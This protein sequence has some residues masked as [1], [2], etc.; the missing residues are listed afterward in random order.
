MDRLEFLK[1]TSRFAGVALAAGSLGWLAGCGGSTLSRDNQP[2]SQNETARVPASSSPAQS[3]QPQNS[4]PASDVKVV[5]CR[6]Y[7]DG[8]CGRTGEKCTECI[9][10]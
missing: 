5:D 6:F 3:T 1:R 2:A 7:D 4:A 8:I 10:R 9:L